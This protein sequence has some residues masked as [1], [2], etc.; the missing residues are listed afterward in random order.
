VTG[1]FSSLTR[2]ADVVGD[3]VAVE[4]DVKVGAAALRHAAQKPG[5][6]ALNVVVVVLAVID[7]ARALRLTLAQ[8]RAGLLER[9]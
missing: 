6:G 9:V 7:A 5:V 2:R 8:H 4:L 3:A 1:T